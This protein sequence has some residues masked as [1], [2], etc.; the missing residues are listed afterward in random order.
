M[1]FTLA[2]V[3]ATSFACAQDKPADSKTPPA[4]G[5][6]KP[7]V[8]PNAGVQGPVSTREAALE[9]YNKGVELF[10]TSQIYAEKGDTD[11]QKQGLRSAI[12]EFEAAFK[13]DPTLIEAKSNMAFAYLTLENRGRA[14]KLFQEVLAQK[15][16][17]L[18]SINGLATTYALDKR[19]DEAVPLLEKLTTLDPSN[20]QYWYNRGSVLHQSGKLEDARKMY[21]KAL[22]FELGHQRSLFNIAT[23]LENQGN[24]TEAKTYYDKAKGVAIGNTIGLEAVRRIQAI[25]T[26][27]SA[28]TTSST[29]EPATTNSGTRP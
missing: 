28:G 21:D 22:S 25:D 11:S 1:A 3:M 24:L 23:L 12:R 6:S 18:N 7:A 19:Y 14:V 5:T 13:Q 27:L 8:A 2:F 4:T 26:R 16:E 20:V 17:H 29:P 10:E 15:P 9:R